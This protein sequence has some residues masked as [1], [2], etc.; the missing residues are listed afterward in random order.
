MLIVSNTPA[1][2]WLAGLPA[3]LAVAG[4]AAGTALWSQLAPTKGRRF[5]L[6]VVNHQLQLFA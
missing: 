3:A 6:V 5:G 4:T 2:Y 1:R